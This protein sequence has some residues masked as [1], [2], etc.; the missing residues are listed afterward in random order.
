MKN[1]AVKSVPVESLD[2]RQPEQGS[3]AGP[4]GKGSPEALV[5]GIGESDIVPNAPADRHRFGGA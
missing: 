5:A 1:L 2:S 4:A 3:A